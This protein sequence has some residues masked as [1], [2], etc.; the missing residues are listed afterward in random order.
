MGILLAS[1]VA[2]FFFV[3]VGVGVDGRGREGWAC[4]SPCY[5]PTHPPIHPGMLKM[6]VDHQMVRQDEISKYNELSGKLRSG[7]KRKAK[8]EEIWSRREKLS[9]KFSR[10]WVSLSTAKTLKHVED[11]SLAS[12]DKIIE[13]ATVSTD[14]NAKVAALQEQMVKISAQL[15]EMNSA[16]RGTETV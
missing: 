3:G 10:C 16:R 1:G 5:R 7:V 6:L 8:R 13:V 4:C 12:H 15:T 11:V 14:T 2:F 9:I